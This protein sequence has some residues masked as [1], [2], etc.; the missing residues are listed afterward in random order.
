MLNEL[1]EIGI[2]I[3]AFAAA[4][5][6]GTLYTIWRIKE[7]LI[8][9]ENGELDISDDEYEEENDKPEFMNIVKEGNVFYAYGNNDRFLTQGND[10][11]T[12]FTNMKKDF[13]ETTWLI[14]SE[15]ESLSDAE[16][17]SIMTTLQVVFAAP[18]E[19]DE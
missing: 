1:L 11:K 4:F 18:K 12:L 5:K 7:E 19:K 13:P 10:L 3:A 14:N 17:D 15:N 2:L 16:R 6:A 9:Y 8:A